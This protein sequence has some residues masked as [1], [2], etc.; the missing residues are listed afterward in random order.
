MS[1]WRL[2]PVM[3]G[4][5]ILQPS[6]SPLCLL[7]G[8]KVLFL[9]CVFMA[10]GPDT[11]ML[12]ML[13]P[14]HFSA[15]NPCCLVVRHCGAE[16]IF[17]HSRMCGHWCSCLIFT[18]MHLQI[19][20]NMNGSYMEPKLWGQCRFQCIRW[21]FSVLNSGFCLHITYFLY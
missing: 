5:A 13:L 7:P 8:D 12:W 21:C 10:D 4:V 19:L 6:Q 2:L 14:R 3:S 11:V 18:T 20:C 17:E 15:V 1:D 16:Q 9:A